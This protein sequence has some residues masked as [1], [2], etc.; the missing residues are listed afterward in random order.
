MDGARGDNCDWTLTVV[1]GSTQVAPLETSGEID[2]D[3]TS[4]PNV[5]NTY[6]TSGE[7][8]ATI[9]EWTING[10]PTGDNTQ[11]LTVDWI[12]NGTF[13]ICVTAKN[14]CDEAPPTCETVTIMSILPQTFDHVIC[15][16]ESVE[17]NDTI[18]L[19]DE[20]NYEFNFLSEEG[21]DSTVFFNV[22]VNKPSTR[23]LAFNICDGDTVFVDGQP[24]FEAGLFTEVLQNRF[25]CRC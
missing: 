7:A 4:C 22:I 16:G 1:E 25:G 15:E 17:V 12:Q 5:S 24:F 2:G 11:E 3:F 9:Y 21:C 14:A 23:D 13:Q 8:G 10:Q 18:T 19:F 6:V 20:G